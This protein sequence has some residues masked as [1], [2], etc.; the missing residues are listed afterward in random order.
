MTAQETKLDTIA[1]NLANVNTTG[2]KRQDAEFEDLLYQ[3][4]RAPTVNAAG[5][6]A[7]AGAQLGSGARIV[8]TSRSFAQGPIQQ[9]S[10]RETVA[11]ALLQGVNAVFHGNR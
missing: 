4:L 3:N 5:G 11:D 2:Y 6:T 10:V 8:S 9:T 1:N 7:P